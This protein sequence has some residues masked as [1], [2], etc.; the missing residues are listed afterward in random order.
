MRKPVSDITTM[1]KIYP[2]LTGFSTEVTNAKFYSAEHS[3]LIVQSNLSLTRD[4]TARISSIS[5]TV[6]EGGG[7]RGGSGGKVTSLRTSQKS[8]CMK[9]RGVWLG[10][11]APHPPSTI[12]NT[13][14]K[15]S[16]KTKV[17]GNTRIYHILDLAYSGQQKANFSHLL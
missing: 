1:S 10:H 2:E 17:D 15:F 12:Y 6:R 4:N 9:G 5:L 14:H 11:C 13:H 3:V 8:R 7:F 16:N